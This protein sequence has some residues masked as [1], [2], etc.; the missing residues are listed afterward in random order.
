MARARRVF[1][2][3]LKLQLPLDITHSLLA[4]LTPSPTLAR[5]CILTYNAV[6][7]FNWVVYAARSRIFMAYATRPPPAVEGARI[8]TR[9]APL[10]PVYP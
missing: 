6:L 9:L 2:G 8:I 7:L 10:D 4:H 1:L 5:T 3:A